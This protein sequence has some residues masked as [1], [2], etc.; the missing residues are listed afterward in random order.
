M[1]VSLLRAR[2]CS[3]PNVRPFDFNIAAF[4]LKFVGSC[5]DVTFEMLFLLFSS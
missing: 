3:V 1:L 5:T 4:G 2:V